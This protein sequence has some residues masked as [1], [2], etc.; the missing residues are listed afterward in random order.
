MPDLILGTEP[1]DLFIT[2]NAGNVVPMTGHDVDGVTATIEY[3]VEVLRVK[4]AILCGHSDCG[5]LKAALD[6]KSLEGLPKARRWL[7][8]VEAALA[9][10]S[11]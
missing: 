8:H 1:G 10:A 2:R 11:R 5:A 6:H 3:A 7:Q 4:H 9:I